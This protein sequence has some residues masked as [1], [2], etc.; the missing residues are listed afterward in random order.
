MHFFSTRVL[1]EFQSGFRKKHSIETILFLTDYI[2]K[3]IDK[4]KLS[5]M[6]LLDLQKAFD[7]IDHSILH[8]KVKA[9]GFSNMVCKWIKSYLENRRQIV[10]LNGVFSDCLDISRQGSVLGPL[11]FYYILTIKI[12]LVQISFYYMQMM[13]Q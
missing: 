6:L 5:G 13:Q 11:L 4:G 7:T 12:W 9:M 2:R 10:D 3:E 1:Y 8:L